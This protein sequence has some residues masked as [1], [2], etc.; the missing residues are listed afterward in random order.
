MLAIAKK[1]FEVKPLYFALR[2]DFPNAEEI[3]A[4]FNKQIDTMI[5]DGTYHDI[6]ELN[7]VKADLNGDGVARTLSGW[8]RCG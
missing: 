4:N 7:W 2:K 1:P 8:R 3:I 6:L 5:T